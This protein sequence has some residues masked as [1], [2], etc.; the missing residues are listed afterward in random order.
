MD[1]WKAD[2]VKSEMG[3]AVKSAK[4]S[5]WRDSSAMQAVTDLV[6]AIAVSALVLGVAAAL[7]HIA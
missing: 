6:I 1:G 5:G 2:A 7:V 4:A 3:K